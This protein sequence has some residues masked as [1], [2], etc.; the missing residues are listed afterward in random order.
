MQ[1]KLIADPLVAERYGVTAMTIW[2]WTQDPS[3]GFPKP[4]TIR[5][6]NYRKVA[7]LDAFDERQRNVALTPRNQTKRC[8]E[9]ARQ[10]LA[11][12]RAEAR[13]E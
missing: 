9:K 13:G 5:T 1:D 3:L 7:E 6:R 10:V 11:R 12:K 8:T 4:I 2:R